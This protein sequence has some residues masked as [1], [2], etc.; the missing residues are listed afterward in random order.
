M[1]ATSGPTW[2]IGNG[3][4]I[5]RDKIAKWQ[6]QIYFAWVKVCCQKAISDF[7]VS[8]RR[9]VTNFSLSDL[10]DQSSQGRGDAVT[11]WGRGGIMA[12]AGR[13]DRTVRSI[14]RRYRKP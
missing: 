6:P 12:T 8:M 5:A 14:N 7:E 4:D 13:E 1:T 11:P 2:N 9:R 3:V 10:A